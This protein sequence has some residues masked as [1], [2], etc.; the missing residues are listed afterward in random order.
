M[1]NQTAIQLYDE[2]VIHQ[3]TLLQKSKSITDEK[4][5]KFIKY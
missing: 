4:E 3:N 5:S 1:N 2:L